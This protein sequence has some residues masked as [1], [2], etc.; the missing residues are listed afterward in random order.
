[1]GQTQ[2]LFVYFRPLLNTMTNTGQN[3]T[4]QTKTVCLGF[5]PGTAEW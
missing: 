1:M 5:K 3:L 4:I 2:R